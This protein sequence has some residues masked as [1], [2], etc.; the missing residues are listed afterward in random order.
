LST[1]DYLCELALAGGRAGRELLIEHLERCVESIDADATLDD[2]HA[3]FAGGANCLIVVQGDF[4]L[5]AITPVQI[6]F[7]Q[8]QQ[9]ARIRRGASS[10]RRSLGQLLQ[11][12]PTIGPGRTLAEAATLLVDHNLDALAV[13]SQSG[14][15]AG[16]LMEEQILRAM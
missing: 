5:G 12:A 13:V 16:V 9:F 14:Q 8:V 3:A 4:P 7:A 15:L 10:A 11:A 2:A 6:A 1:S